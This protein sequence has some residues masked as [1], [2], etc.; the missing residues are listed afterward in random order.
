MSARLLIPPAAEPI[1]LDQ[2]KAQ[3][4]IT[5]PDQDANIARAIAAARSSVETFCERALITSTWRLA[6]TITAREIALG[7]IEIAPSP[8]ASIESVTVIDPP[9]APPVPAPSVIR[10]LGPVIPSVRALGP[11][12]YR[13]DLDVEPARLYLTDGLAGIRRIGVTFVAGYGADGTAV[14]PAL[15]QILLQLVGMY[16]EHRED[17]AEGARLDVLP[18]GHSARVALEP[19]RVLAL[20]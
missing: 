6:A 2:A 19:W 3:I 20:A 15:V 16:F 5:A 13:V 10:T 1:T 8:V 4:P 12:A 14:P 18:G 7:Y 11:E 17:V 9:E